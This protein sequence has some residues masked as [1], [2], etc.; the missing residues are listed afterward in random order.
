MKLLRRSKKEEKAGSEYPDYISPAFRTIFERFAHATM[1]NWPGCYQSYQAACY[2][3]DAQIPGAVVECG[4]WQ[5]GVSA[6]MAEALAA[7]GDTDRP[8]YLF[9]SFEGIPEPGGYDFRVFQPEVRALDLYSQRDD[10]GKAAPAE[11]AETLSLC[12]YPQ[13]R[14]HIVAGDVLKTLPDQAPDQIALL[15]LDT[16]WFDSTRH[17]MQH[18]Y[19]RLSPGGVLIVDDYWYWDGARQAVDQ[20]LN[21]HGLRLFLCADSHYHGVSAV[22]LA[23]QRDPEFGVGE[24]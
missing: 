16:D 10:W 17:E 4:V 24:R 14:F 6:V 1:V 8:F 19:P 2:V 20:Y 23:D 12:S 11:L 18:L 13:D 22:K 5:G 15:R 9:D 21:E 3:A 7:A